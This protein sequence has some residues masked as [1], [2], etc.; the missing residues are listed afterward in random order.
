MRYW[1]RLSGGV[2]KEEENEK[3]FD[4]VDK[5]I[6]PTTSVIRLSARTTTWSKY[7]ER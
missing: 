1:L 3:H 5:F 6:P 4:K 7:S 2:E